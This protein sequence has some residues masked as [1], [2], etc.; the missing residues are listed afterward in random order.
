MGGED[1]CGQCHWGLR[2][3]SLWATK[4]CPGCGWRM[5][6]VPLAGPPDGA[7]KR[8]TGWEKRMRAVPL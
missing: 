6:A 7:T 4:R 1:A 5:R 3:G 8:C 2:W